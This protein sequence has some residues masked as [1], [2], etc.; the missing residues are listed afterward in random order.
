M[1]MN[2]ENKNHVHHAVVHKHSLHVS[3]TT[4]LRAAISK[5]R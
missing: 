4:D 1:L 3:P 2:V 5:R